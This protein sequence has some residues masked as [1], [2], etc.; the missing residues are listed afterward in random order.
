MLK[1][2]NSCGAAAAALY[3]LT[4]SFVL[5]KKDLHF[6]RFC[7]EARRDSNGGYQ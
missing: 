5:A 1:E 2:R 3:T 7:L 6:T 4:L